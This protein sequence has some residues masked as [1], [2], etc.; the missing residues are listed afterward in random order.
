MC[1]CSYM[2]VYIYLQQINYLKK[3]RLFKKYIKCR[4]Y[5]KNI[6]PQENKNYRNILSTIL[7][8]SKKHY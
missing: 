6:L 7:K 4:D 5:N 3:N 8:Q 2:D 1:I